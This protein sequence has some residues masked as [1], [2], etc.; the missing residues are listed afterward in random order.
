MIIVIT[1]LHADSEMRWC[2]KH[3]VSRVPYAI[4]DGGTICLHSGTAFT[5]CEMVGIHFVEIKR[6]NSE[7]L[8]D[9]VLDS[10]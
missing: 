4:E 7:V 1:I 8:L 2:D 9:S 10:L 6:A 5:N 3:T